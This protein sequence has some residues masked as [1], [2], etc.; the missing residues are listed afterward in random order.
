MIKCDICGKEGQKSPGMFA[1]HFKNC[2][3]NDNN[4]IDEKE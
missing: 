3:Q 4:K 1:F 2:K